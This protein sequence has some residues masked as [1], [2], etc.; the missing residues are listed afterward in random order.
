MEGTTGDMG[1]GIERKVGMAIMAHP[2]D[3][4]FGA[5]GTIA[6]WIREGWTFY[7]VICTDGGGGGSDLA[8]DCSAGPR[9]ELTKLRK[10]EQRNAG[11]ELGLADIFF[12][13]HRDG[14]LED[15][16]EL[17][18]ELVRLI[19]RYR[20]SR[21]LCPS[22]DRVWE[23]EYHVKRH[24]PDHLACGAAALAALYPA[25]QNP[26]DYPELLE[27]GLAP[28][29][30]SEFYVT[31]APVVNYAE[32]ISETIDVKIAALGEHK[33]Q[34]G[35]RIDDLGEMLR[36]NAKDRGKEHGVKMAEVFHRIENS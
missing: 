7:Y 27:Q 3:Y 22:P 23:P 21:V 29:Q 14:Q 33:S 4:E 36:T 10:R 24:H 6:K 9:K 30:V 12:L 28:H 17:R 8:T 25:A 18:R 5:A 2:D 16:V 15:N 20:P 32:D 35:I 19:R 13:D 1:E 34:V 26:W 31:G 11:A